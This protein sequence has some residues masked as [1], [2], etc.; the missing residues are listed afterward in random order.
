MDRDDAILEYLQGRLPPADRANFEEAMAQDASLVAEVDLMRAVRTTLAAAPKH[1]K[2]QDVWNQLAAQIDPAPIPANDNHIPWM[3][4]LRYAAVASLAVA[5]WQFTV[6]PRTGQMTDGF[7][8][9]SEATPALVLQVKFRETAT[10]A[11]IG[12]VLLP[13]GG[14]IVDGPSALGL[15]RV[16]YPDEAARASA[17]QALEAQDDLVEFVLDQ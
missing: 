8:T 14:T 17:K 1:A 7:R 3:Q 10:L 13:A 4:L 16:S 5:V 12:A 6:V 2:S 9:S 11:Q 15:V